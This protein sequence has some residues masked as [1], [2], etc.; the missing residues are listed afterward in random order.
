MT[1]Q[2]ASHVHLPALEHVSMVDN[3]LVVDVQGL[4]Y[5]MYSCIC[6]TVCYNLAIKFHIISEF[7]LV[8]MF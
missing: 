7:D 5:E 8:S 3:S 1:D 6:N 2:R 4:I